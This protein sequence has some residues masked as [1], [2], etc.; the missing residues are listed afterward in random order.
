MIYMN[1]GNYSDDVNYDLIAL[2]YWPKVSDV[3]T[4]RLKQ[5]ET[6]GVSPDNIFMYGH[7]L[8]GRMVIDAAIQFGKGKIAQ[9]DSKSNWLESDSK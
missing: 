2:S 8:G 5:L 1:W 4:R 7:S 6:E 9:I 3:L